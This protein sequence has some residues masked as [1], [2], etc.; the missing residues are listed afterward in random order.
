MKL[1]TKGFTIVELIVAIVVGPI[2][3]GSAILL[4][5]SHLHLSQRNRDLVIMNAYVENK[6][7]SLRSLGFAG[8]SDGTT[9]LSGELPAELSAPRSGS[10]QISTFST[11]V[12][13]VN[14]SINYNDQG[15][16]RTYSY[17]TLIGELGVGQY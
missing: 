14:I 10:L 5:V 9:S 12:K 11:A 8:L 1:D 15:A 6:V 13:R 7:E 2:I 3:V 16:S 17:S 4:L